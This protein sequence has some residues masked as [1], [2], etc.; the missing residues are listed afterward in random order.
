MAETELDIV[1]EWK[2]GG[3]FV[4]RGPWYKTHFENN[5]RILAFEPSKHL[6]YSH[7]SSLSRLPDMPENY[8]IIDF[9]LSDAENKTA[10]TV[11]ASNFPTE[12]IYRH[13]AFYWNVTIELLKKFVEAGYQSPIER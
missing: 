10:L 11:T 13:F 1:T 12:A 6:R 5:G 4:I 7:L 3:P 2:V 9:M 8:T